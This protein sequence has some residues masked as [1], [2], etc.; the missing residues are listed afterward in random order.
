HPAAFAAFEK[1][2][3]LRTARLQLESRSVWYNLY[4]T[5]GVESDVR[6]EVYRARSDEDM[7]ACVDWLYKGAKLPG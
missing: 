5:G 2:R 7:W 1:A 6:N 3:F 4:H